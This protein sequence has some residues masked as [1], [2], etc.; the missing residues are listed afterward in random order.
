MK[1]HES[2]SWV[3]LFAQRLKACLFTVQEMPQFPLH[4][5]TIVCFPRT[6]VK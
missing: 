2:I 1:Q 4:V 6:A 5:E 3:G